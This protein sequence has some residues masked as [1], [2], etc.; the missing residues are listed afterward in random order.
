[1]P[2]SPPC[3]TSAGL[4]S[5]HGNR[6]II[7]RPHMNRFFGVRPD[8]RRTVWLGVVTLLTIV[9]AH[10]VLET[11]RDALFLADLPASRLP[12]AYLGIAVLAYI[13]ARVVERLLGTRSARGA[14]AAMLLVGATGTAILWDL[15]ATSVP[16]SLMALYIWTGVLAS[17]VLSQFWIQLAAQMDVGQAKRAY[18]LIA[19]G[20]MLGA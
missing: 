4:P 6:S 18:A 16:A 11:A 2:G 8:E 12:W 15:V 17:V 5:W 7:G 9:A 13:A 19:A 10:T 3:R 20:G 1:M 14:L